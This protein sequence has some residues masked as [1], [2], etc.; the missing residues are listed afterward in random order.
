VS[1]VIVKNARPF[2]KHL[3]GKTSLL[4]ELLE[5]TPS[6]FGRYYEPFVGGGALFFALATRP[7]LSPFVASLNDTNERLIRTYSALRYDVELV[8]KRLIRLS[9]N[10][11]EEAFYKIRKKLPEAMKTNSEAAAWYIYLNKTC[12]NGLYRVNKKNEFNVPFGK[13]ASP[14]ICDTRNLRAV[15]ET[16]K[17]VALT[18]V[19]YRTA[20]AKVKRGDFIFYDP[21]YLKRTKTDFVA[22]GPDHFGVPQHIELR[23]LALEQKKKGIHVMITNSGSDVV[24]D[25]YSSKQFKITETRG[26]RSVGASATTRGTMPDLLIT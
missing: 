22:Y 25:L 12:F 8:I 14:H 18:A 1:K 17:G 13:Y 10:H 7:R 24:R 4:P 26:R 5:H 23:D 3:G 21:P 11:S 15:S 19:D 2:I 20:T 16:L 9:D 6:T